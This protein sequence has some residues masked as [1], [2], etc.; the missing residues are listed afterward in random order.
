MADHAHHLVRRSFLAGD[1]KWVRMPD[2]VEIGN[3]TAMCAS[4]HQLVTENVAMIAYDNELFYWTMDE[5]VFTELTQQPPRLDNMI[6][7]TEQ[8]VHTREQKEVCPACNR[9]LPKPKIETPMEEK[10]QRATWAISVPADERENGYEVLDTLLDEARDAL[11]RAGMHYDKGNK[12]RYYPLATAL[13]LFVQF[14]DRILS[15]E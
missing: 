9:P 15:D 14:S 6:H 5:H 7:V 10:K 11:D 4:H 12:V 1:Y 2:G 3:L 8:Q 13:G